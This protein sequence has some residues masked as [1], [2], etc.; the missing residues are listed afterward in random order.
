[1]NLSDKALVFAA[2]LALAGCSNGPVDE[3]SGSPEIIEVFAC[4]DNCPGPREQY[5]KRVFAGV[6]DED[7]CRK[8]GG[9]PYTYVGW[10]KRTVCEV[11][12]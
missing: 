7:E 11:P 9:R 10:G 8:L 1:M 6:T 3:D 2:S 4:S 12:K 5:I